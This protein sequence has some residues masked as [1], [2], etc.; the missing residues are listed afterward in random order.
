MREQTMYVHAGLQSALAGLVVVAVLGLPGSAR[1]QPVEDFYRGKIFRL[2]VGADA[3]GEYD[4][5]A[6]LLSRHLGKHIPGRPT[7]IVQNMPGASGIKA[8]NYLYS[9]AERDGTVLATFNQ[10][11][12]VYEATRMANTNFKSAEFNWIGS[13]THSNTLVVVAARTGVKTIA[14]A[15]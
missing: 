2:V 12:P 13:L 9:I 11:M 4:A 3:T 15:T 10:G 8:A 6:R 7:I 14:D 5:S 1:A